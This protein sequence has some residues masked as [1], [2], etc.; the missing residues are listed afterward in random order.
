MKYLRRLIWFAANRLLALAVVLTM[1][2]IAFYFSMNAA[3]IYVILK[4]GMAERAQTVMIEETPGRLEKYFAKSY[5]DRDNVLT[6]TRTGTNPYARYSITGF[7]H[8][9]SME[10]MWC[11]P[12]DTTARAE[13]TETIPRIDGRVKSSSAD[14]ARALYSDGFEYP[15]KWQGGRYAATLVKENGQWHVRSLTLLAQVDE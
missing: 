10:W 7:D 6:S 12:W 13:F 5:I 14:A 1:M 15:P 8:R 9:L 11:W 4:D 3:N 2:T